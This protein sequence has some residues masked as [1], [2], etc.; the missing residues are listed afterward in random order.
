MR[1]RK[2]ERMRIKLSLTH[3]AAKCLKEP[4]MTKRWEMTGIQGN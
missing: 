1:E 4:A 2:R 3:I